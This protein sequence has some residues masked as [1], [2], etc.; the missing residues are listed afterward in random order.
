MNFYSIIYVYYTFIFYI[1]IPINIINDTI[2]KFEQYHYL[3]GDNSSDN[4]I[5]INIYIHKLYICMN[6]F[7]RVN[8]P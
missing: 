4:A 2:T 1:G 8:K 5:C 6:L 7:Y 3:I